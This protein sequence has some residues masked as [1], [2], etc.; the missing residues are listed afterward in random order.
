VKS[1]RKGLSLEEIENEVR[2]LDPEVSRDELGFRTAVVL[3]AASFAVGPNV[4]GLASFTGYPVS[5][6]ADISR[7]MC[8][9]G[10]WTADHV[11][12]DHWF[13]GDCIVSSFWADTLVAEGLAIARR[14]D[15]GSGNT[16]PWLGARCNRGETRPARRQGKQLE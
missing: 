14:T 9:C 15:D 10:L 6:V 3:L 1:A 12:T 13:E 4:G 5:F 16:E 2:Q 8:N 7:R 11:E